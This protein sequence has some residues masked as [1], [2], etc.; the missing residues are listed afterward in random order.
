MPP[1][2]LESHRSTSR[3]MTE[4]ETVASTPS[5]PADN[6]D[7]DEEEVSPNALRVLLKKDT[8]ALEALEA[9]VADSPGWSPQATAI[10]REE[11]PE[12]AGTK[13]E[14]ASAAEKEDLAVARLCRYHWKLKQRQS[15]D[16]TMIKSPS[17]PTSSSHS[18]VNKS[19]LGVTPAEVRRPPFMYLTEAVLCS[20]G[21]CS[22]RRELELKADRYW[23]AGNWDK[24]LGTKPRPCE[25]VLT[26]MKVDL[27]FR[28]R[29][30]RVRKDI[31]WISPLQ[32][33]IM[34][35]TF[36]QVFEIEVPKTHRVLKKSATIV[37]TAWL[38]YE[39]EIKRVESEIRRSMGSGDWC[40]E[41]VVV[42]CSLQVSWK[43]YFQ[44]YRTLRFLEAKGV[45]HFAID[46]NSDIGTDTVDYNAIRV[47]LKEE[48]LHRDHN[49]R[50]GVMNCLVPQVL[51]DGVPLGTYEEI[52]TMEDE[53]DLGTATKVDIQSPLPSIEITQ[54][55]NPNILV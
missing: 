16:H 43:A 40:A 25:L 44:S 19:L 9:V 54:Y 36:D 30:G 32:K 20:C 6:Y 7:K 3:L 14:T 1:L 27:I 46:I 45:D 47:W 49:K 18:L 42:V 52:L 21:P 5:G 24:A 10:Q 17:H 13:K 35:V 12:Y 22:E 11:Y 29:R 48:L 8:I 51:V 38:K 4:S 23:L 37:D 26:D 31:D 41:V 33:A 53:N 2:S 28:K 50:E 55:R 15:M 39:E 34:T